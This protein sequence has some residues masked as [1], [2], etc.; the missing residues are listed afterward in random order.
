MNNSKVMNYSI[1]DKNEFQ[2]KQTTIP[3]KKIDYSRFDLWHKIMDYMNFNELVKCAGVSK[4]F[5]LQCSQD[6]LYKK[7][8]NTLHE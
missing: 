5:F 4:F 8:E 7:F 2:I 6:H 3:Y 1:T